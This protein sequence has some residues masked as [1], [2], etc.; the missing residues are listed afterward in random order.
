MSEAQRLE[1]SV[2]SAAIEEHGICV[3]T[4]TSEISKAGLWPETSIKSLLI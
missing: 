3:A 4:D 1:V 2:L